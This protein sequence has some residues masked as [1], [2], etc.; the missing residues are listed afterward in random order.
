MLFT[1]QMI[2]Y[3]VIILL[4]IISL[5]WMSSQVLDWFWTIVS[6]YTREQMGRLL[7][8]TTGCSQLPP[9]GFAELSPKFQLTAAPTYG[10]LPTAHTW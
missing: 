5:C 2:V 1:E 6:G 9:G 4:F 8:F 10:N 3:N 7:Q